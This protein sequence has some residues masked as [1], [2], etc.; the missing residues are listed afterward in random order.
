MPGRAKSGHAGPLLCELHAHTTWSDGLLS[1]RQ[2][3]DLYGA[4]GFD[5][6]AITDHVVRVEDPWFAA[7]TGEAQQRARELYSLLVVP[8][9]EL[10]YNDADPTRAA[11]AVAIGL[12]SFVPVDTGIEPALAAARAAGAALVAAH[13]YPLE[14]A[15]LSTR[16]TARFAEEAEWAASVVDRFELVNRHELFPWVAA[17]RLPV[18]ASGDFHRLPHFATWKTL[19]PAA[20]SAEALVE[21][22]RSDGAIALTRLDRE[23]DAA[24]IAA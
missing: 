12:R 17:A 3:V 5:V 2:L 4:G 1:L 10:T 14:L 21:Y 23:P 18:V 20:K 19:V 13:P 7:A 9:L 8:G 24:P 16:T 15:G 11:H 6:L 22:L